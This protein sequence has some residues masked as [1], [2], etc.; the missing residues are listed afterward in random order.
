MPQFSLG[1]RNLNNRETLD[2]RDRME[3]VLF[4]SP[5]VGE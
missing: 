4:L 2:D 5:S 3:N 1:K